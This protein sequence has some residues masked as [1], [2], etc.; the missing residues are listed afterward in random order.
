MKHNREAARATKFELSQD[1]NFT[2]IQVKQFQLVVDIRLSR[3]GKRRKKG[4][5]SRAFFS[6]DGLAL[7]PIIRGRGK[8]DPINRS[9]LGRQGVFREIKCVRHRR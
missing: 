9:G 2:E 1:D 8:Y 6:S 7:V 4:F 5:L 3:S